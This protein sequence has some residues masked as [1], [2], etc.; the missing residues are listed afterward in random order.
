MP[1]R[2]V[3]AQRI[4]QALKDNTVPRRE[5]PYRLRLKSPLDQGT[6]L[7]RELAQEIVDESKTK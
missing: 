1:D 4:L 5:D 7:L 3:I 2:L 6:R